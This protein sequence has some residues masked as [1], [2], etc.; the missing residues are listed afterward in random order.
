LFANVNKNT[1]LESVGCV[2]C[3]LLQIMYFPPFSYSS[4]GVPPFVPLYLTIPS[5]SYSW[6]SSTFAP[7]GSLTFLTAYGAQGGKIEVS[8]A[9]DTV[10]WTFNPSSTAGSFFYAVNYS[11]GV[12]TAPVKVTLQAQHK[13]VQMRKL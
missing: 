8:F 4:F 9:K 3:F 7:G 11:I 1:K 10:T 5:S 2:V 12:Q 13:R 6:H